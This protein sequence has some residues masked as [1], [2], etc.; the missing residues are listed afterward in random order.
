[1]FWCVVLLSRCWSCNAGSSLL[2]LITKWNS[3]PETV[4]AGE[5]HVAEF[6]SLIPLT[7]L[8]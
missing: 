3:N 1:M 7:S 6:L 8:T 4:V 2:G 5:L